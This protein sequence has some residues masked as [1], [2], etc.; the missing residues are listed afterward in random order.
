VDE[1]EWIKDSSKSMEAEK[2]KFSLMQWGTHILCV[3]VCVC[4]AIIQEQMKLVV[5][6]R[7]QL[8]GKVHGI[9]VEESRNWQTMKRHT[10]W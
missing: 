8:T 9:E 5:A 2:Y 4:V 10:S 3:C 6:M 1:N 7:K